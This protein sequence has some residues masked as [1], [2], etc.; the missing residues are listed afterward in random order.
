MPDNFIPAIKKGYY[1]AVEKGPLSGNKVT[2]IHF[3]LKDGAS[4]S[5]DSTEIAFI[6]AAEGAM[7]QV[8][9]EGKWQIIEPIMFVEVTAPEEFQSTVVGNINKRNGIISNSETNLGWFNIQCEV[10]LNDMFGYCKKIF[11]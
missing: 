3:R 7:K 6:L 9:S 5:T 8:Y 11:Y 1:K 2:G 10:A 4:H